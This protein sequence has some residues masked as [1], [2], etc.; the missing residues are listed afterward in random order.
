VENN[1]TVLAK[2][3]VLTKKYLRRKDYI[4]FSMAKFAV[5][6]IVGLTQ[7]YLL[8]FYTSVMGIN[9]VMVGVMFLVA[10]IFD[11]LNDP[12]MG[13][14]VDKTKTRL[15][16]MRPYLIFGAIPF[17]VI[18]ILLFV[19]LGDMSAAG[20]LVYMYVTYIGYGILGTVVNVPMDGLPAVASPN[21]EE[22]TKII[23]VSRI[24][25][26]IGEQ[27]ALV[28]Y[29]LFALFLNMKETYMVMGIVI[30]I[31]APIFMLLGVFNLK[32][33]IP[34]SKV[35]PKIL[36][37]FKYL[38]KNKQFLALIS[39]LLL[40]F[41][42]NLVTATIIY[43]V[44]YI[45][46]NGSLNI[47]FALPGAVA[48]MLGMLFA[49]KLRKKFDP[50]TIFIGSTLIHSAGLLLVYFVG[51]NVP[52]FVT[53][54]LMAVAMLPVGLL[55]VVPHFMAI[56]TLDYW[57]DKTGSRNEGVTFA[58]ISLRS[59]ISSAFKD[60]VFAGLLSFFFFTTPLLTINNHSPAQLA[61]TQSGI[62]MIFTIIPAVLN[63]VSIL[64]M[65]LY[66][67]SGKRMAEI[68][69]RLSIK[70]A[71]MMSENGGEGAVGAEQTENDND[72]GAVFDSDG[73]AISQIYETDAPDVTGGV[74]PESASYNYDE[75]D[76]GESI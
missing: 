1:E 72:A 7:G 15:G 74:Q 20:K 54:I 26:S 71:E 64:P 18:T 33:R 27:S 66:K 35:P 63:L 39:S 31:L 21:N 16:K 59:K 41:F 25:G 49:P 13:V 42:R 60:F 37:G 29:S 68:T 12:I 11:G 44:T 48:S 55:N 38:F 24:V 8:I 62:F 47:F 67:L 19:P 30:G 32:E 6:A 61:F 40:S 3:D 17:G 43:V 9:P 51:F 73:G 52:W 50:K 53:A 46:S 57:E 70:R 76:G 22:R 75:S 69:A 58:I 36:D 2:D 10:K 28:L 56:D 5:S 65:M 23:S 45:Y 14:I 34:P 4:T